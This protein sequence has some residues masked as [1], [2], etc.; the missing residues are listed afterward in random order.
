MMIILLHT[1]LRLAVRATQLHVQ[2]V[3]TDLPHTCDSD[4]SETSGA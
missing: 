3:P 1:V 2:W 4:I